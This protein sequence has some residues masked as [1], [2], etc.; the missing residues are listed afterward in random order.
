M[1]SSEIRR[2][3]PNV[4]KAEG[5]TTWQ[6]QPHPSNSPIKV[7]GNLSFFY[8]IG[9]NCG[10]LSNLCHVVYATKGFSVSDIGD[11]NL[12][13]PLKEKDP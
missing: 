6:N 2:V 5:G 12:S 9:N 13:C 3:H 4:A 10:P 11:S 1:R 8:D 7:S